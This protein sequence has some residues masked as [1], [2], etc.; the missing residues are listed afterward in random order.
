MTSVALAQQGQILGIYTRRVCAPAYKMLRRDTPTIQASSGS[1]AVQCPAQTQRAATAMAD[2]ATGDQRRADRGRSRGRHLL[3]IVAVWCRCSSRRSRV[4]CENRVRS[5]WVSSPGKRPASRAWHFRWCR[6]YFRQYGDKIRFLCC[7]WIPT[8][9]LGKYANLGLP[10]RVGSTALY[11]TV[12]PELMV[13]YDHFD[14]G[15][16]TAAIFSTYDDRA[17]NGVAVRGW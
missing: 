12:S 16:K 7:E 8:Y 11:Y 6:D 5:S 14:S 1:Y 3:L 17:A 13:Q 2:T 9:Q 4:F 15:T 10:N